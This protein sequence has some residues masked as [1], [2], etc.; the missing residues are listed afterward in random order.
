MSAP[1]MN[2]R[3]T[4]F[5]AALVIALV[6]IPAFASAATGTSTHANLAGSAGYCQPFAPAPAPS[7]GRAQIATTAAADPGFHAVHLD[8]KVG[9]GKLGAGSYDVWLVNLY[10]DDAGQVIGCSATQAGAMTVK[11][12]PATFRGAV[13]RY[14]GRY[15]VQVYVGPIW[16]PGYATPPVTVD[17]P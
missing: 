12:G 7:L 11:N 14:T 6:A 8:I 9:G 5:V 13:E 16:G 17:V 15:E 10:R 1:S 2:R 4:V 3:R